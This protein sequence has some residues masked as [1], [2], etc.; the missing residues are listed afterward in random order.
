MPH[1]ARHFARGAAAIL[2]LAL[3]SGCIAMDRNAGLAMHS[4]YP[5]ST[6]DAASVTPEEL[7]SA[8]LRAGFTRDEILRDGPAVRNAL[9]TVGSVQVRE[10]KLVKALFSVHADQLYV[11]SRLRGTFIQRLSDPGGEHIPVLLPEPPME[12]HVVPL[13]SEAESVTEDLVED[14]GQEPAEELA[15]EEVEPRRRIHQRGA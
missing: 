12:L 15:E 10:E 5:L 14:L 2:L 8:M 4:V 7:A 3:G 11:S 1:T 9:A 6:G 13:V